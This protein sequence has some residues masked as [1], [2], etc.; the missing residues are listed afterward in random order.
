MH[1]SL[2]PDIFHGNATWR[3]SP[4]PHDR[5]QGIRL[6]LAK[7]AFQPGEGPSRFQATTCN[8]VEGFRV[9]GIPHLTAKI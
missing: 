4:E 3:F 1:E 9:Y 5:A 6:G 7:D 8:I 2:G